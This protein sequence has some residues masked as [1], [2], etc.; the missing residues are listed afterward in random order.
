M[1]SAELRRWM[2]TNTG[3]DEMTLTGIFLNGYGG[4]CLGNS[5]NDPEHEFTLAAAEVSSLQ[6]LWE[7]DIN[8]ATTWPSQ[9]SAFLFKVLAG[10]G[11]LLVQPTFAASSRPHRDTLFSPGGLQHHSRPEWT[12]SPL[13]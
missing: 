2:F 12:L 7:D 10:T 4:I 8:A 6:D 1:R 11:P 13:Q 3:A 9:A 5:L